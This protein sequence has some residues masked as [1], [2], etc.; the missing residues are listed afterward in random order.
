[1]AVTGAS[2]A[3]HA[4]GLD[5]QLVCSKVRPDE[6]GVYATSTLGQLQDEGWGGVLRS[7]LLGGRANSKQVPMALGSMPADFINAYVLGNVGHTEAIAGACASYLYNLQ[8]AVRDIQQGRRRV[9]VVGSSEAPINLENLEGFMAMSAL[10]TEESMRKVDGVEADPRSYSRPFC[11]NGGFVMGESTQYMVLMDDALAVE[12]GADIFA[13]V[14]GVFMDADGIKKSISSPGPGNYLTFAKAMGLCNSILGD[15]G[16]REHS[17][18]MAHG[19]S[20]PQNRITESKIF[21]RLAQVFD[22]HN[23]P[24]AAVKA[25]LGHSMAV[26]S[27]DQI[28]TAIGA[29][30]HGVIPGIKTASAIADDV[31]QERLNIPLTDLDC[32]PD[33]LKACFINAKGFGGNNATG[34]VFS[35]AQAQAMVAKRYSHLWTDYCRRREAVREAAHRYETRADRG[36][37]DVIYRFGENMINDDELLITPKAL[38]VPGYGLPVVLQEENPF[39]D[40]T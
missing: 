31:Y 11:E 16:L 32:G 35:A 38:S 17:W 2:D 13:A 4:L 27:G 8:A 14:P 1:M 19:S 12:L 7:R 36:E 18:I 9:A 20:T 39:A 5:W 6:I 26:A 10:A 22:I 28:I 24:V 15:K 30:R 3:L 29:M 40:M 23:W 21:D 33:Q 25:Y 37:L 34:V